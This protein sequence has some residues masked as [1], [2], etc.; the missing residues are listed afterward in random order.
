MRT[1]ILGRVQ[2][3]AALGAFFAVLSSGSAARA[4]T[5]LEVGDNGSEQM[6]RGGAWVARASDP[7][8]TFYNPAGLAGQATKVT[9]QANINMMSTC[10]SRIK[11][12]ND[13]TTGDGVAAGGAYPKVCNNGSPFPDPQIAF[14]YRLAPRVGLGL[15]IVGPSAAGKADWPDTVNGN[16][17]AQRYLLLS[18]NTLLLTPT[19]AVGWEPIDNLRLGAGF[20]WGAAN[21]DFTNMALTANQ[22]GVAGLQGGG[23]IEAELKAH[24]NFI[25][26]FTLGALWSATDKLD[27]AAW[28]KYMAPLSASGDIITTSGTGNNQYI[29]STAGTDCTLQPGAGYTGCKP[30]GVSVNVPIP[31]E[32]KLGVRVHIPRPG[33]DMLHRR[34]PM[35]QD[36]FDVEANLTWAHNSQFK[37]IGITIPAN[38]GVL[39]LPSGF[40]TDA[41]VPHN[42]K[43]VVGVRLGGDYNVL[44]D[45]LALRAG[46]YFET[47]AQDAQWQNID[48]V[49]GSKIGIAGGAT[50]RIH[51]S[52]TTGNALEFMVGIGHT[53]IASTTDNGNNPQN[54][55]LKALAGTPCN[56]S[57][58]VNASA[59]SAPASGVCPSGSQS[60]RSEWPVNLGTITNAFT[61]IN[62]GVSYKF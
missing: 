47:A 30:N 56:T 21:V 44:P 10:F 26:G 6:A 27:V 2:A 17:A 62:L 45:Q 4:T 43:D 18:A 38:I 15:A 40:P 50:Y 1:S 31:M 7:L 39:G 29:G 8:A 55:G 22:P 19:V 49:A 53:F 14:T 36:V 37:D 33:A 58:A 11:A 51:L 28:Y 3:V 13:T 59:N 52:E 16:P 41:S 48:F 34:D 61:Q 25:P 32:A 23:D 24:A 60:F 9:L 54:S 12:M 35:S 20:I 57:I 42:F 5:A 46:G